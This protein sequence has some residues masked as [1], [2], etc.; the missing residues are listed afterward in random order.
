MSNAQVVYCTLLAFPL[1]LY[2]TISYRFH[3]CVQTT[4]S[5]PIFRSPACPRYP[6]GCLEGWTLSKLIQ[7]TTFLEDRNSSFLQRFHKLSQVHQISRLFLEPLQPCLFI[8]ARSSLNKHRA[9]SQ[10]FILSL[11]SAFVHKSTKQ[12][13]QH[14][15]LWIINDLQ[16]ILHTITLKRGYS[17]HVT[18]P[19]QKSTCNSFSR[20]SPSEERKTWP[21]QIEILWKIAN[22]LPAFPFQPS[23]GYN[24]ADQV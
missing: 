19:L 17:C 15:V 23:L 22:A 21:T 18:S 9:F 1:S 14:N 16:H 4:I 2:S 7:L 3:Y 6:K 8:S 12:W 13:E 20:N 5:L 10:L 11:S 24:F